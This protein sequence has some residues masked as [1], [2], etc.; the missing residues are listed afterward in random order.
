MMN[1]APAKDR[2]SNRTTTGMEMTKPLKKGVSKAMAVT[3][4]LD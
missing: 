3:G 2:K 1:M 4:E